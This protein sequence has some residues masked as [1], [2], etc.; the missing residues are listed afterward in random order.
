MKAKRRRRRRRRRGEANKQSMR[1][2][3]QSDTKVPIQDTE[4]ASPATVI[5]NGQTANWNQPL[6]TNKTTAAAAANER[7]CFSTS[8]ASSAASLGACDGKDETRKRKQ[9]QGAATA[10]RVLCNLVTMPTTGESDGGRQSIP[11]PQICVS[12]LR[13]F[14]SSWGMSRAGKATW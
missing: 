5:A 9:K 6:S 1:Q 12:S 4:Y 8:V 10:S 3:R 7:V 13:V 11:A 14:E 2:S